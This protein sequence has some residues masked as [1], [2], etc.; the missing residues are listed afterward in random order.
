MLSVCLTRDTLGGAALVTAFCPAMQRWARLCLLVIALCRD[1]GVCAC[2]GA[3]L[4]WRCLV[5]AYKVVQTFRATPVLTYFWRTLQELV[6]AY[7]YTEHEF[8]RCDGCPES[9]AQQRIK[10]F[11]ALEQSREKASPNAR[12]LS[13]VL[14]TKFADTRFATGMSGMIFFNHRFPHTDQ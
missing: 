13:E 9:V 2:A 8:F 10:G 11:E 5:H 4:A 3:F 14:R 12:V 7:T 6:P 1:D